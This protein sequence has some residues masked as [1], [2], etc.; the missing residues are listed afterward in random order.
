MIS[1]DTTELQYPSP[2]LLPLSLAAISIP[3][4][5]SSELQGSNDQ[6][7]IVDN[8]LQDTSRHETSGSNI[9]V[10]LAYNMLKKTKFDSI[11][12]F[13][14]NGVTTLCK[15]VHVYDGDTFSIVFLN[16]NAD[17]RSAN[18]IIK[19]RCRLAH[20]D[21]PEMKKDVDKKGKR[22]RNRLVQLITSC[23]ISLDDD[24]KTNS[25]TK[26][27]DEQNTLLVKVE[28]LEFDKYG[29]LMVN[30]YSPDGNSASET[31]IKE[32]YGYSYEGGKKGVVCT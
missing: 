2:L 9:D 23:D 22:A 21:T 20:I 7:V 14:F 29:R 13:S 26:M 11:P 18:G 30:I 5:N 1:V 32:N 4:N 16:N 12:Y 19:M 3:D 25:L 8:E 28:M 15:V 24:I 10:E 31:L 27:L 17:Y 6:Y